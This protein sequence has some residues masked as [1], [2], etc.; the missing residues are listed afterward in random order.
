VKK[1]SFIKHNYF[2]NKNL[3]FK[4]IKVINIILIIF[5][6]LLSA[7]WFTRFYKIKKLKKELSTSNISLDK[8]D[9]M[10]REKNTLLLEKE[11]LESELSLLKQFNKSSSENFLAN[12]L[13]DIL[14]IISK[15]IVLTK[16]DI[17]LINKQVI[18]YGNGKSPVEIFDFLNNLL[19]LDYVADGKLNFIETINKNMNNNFLIKL[20]INYGQNKTT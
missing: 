16:L 5:S 17:S 4:I 14:N 20:D 11:E 1:I 6:F 19:S 9:N 10:V 2:K 13:I 12:I 8:F 15:N 3:V 7:N 18:I